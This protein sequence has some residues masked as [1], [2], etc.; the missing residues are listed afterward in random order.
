MIIIEDNQKYKKSYDH[1]T[2]IKNIIWKKIIEKFYRTNLS[3]IFN[4]YKYIY[5]CVCVC[6]C[7]YI[8]GAFIKVPDFFCTGI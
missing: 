4:I 1:D 6:V 7:I 8:R 3:F 2:M 5:I